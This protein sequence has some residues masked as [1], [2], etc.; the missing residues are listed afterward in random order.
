MF[1]ELHRYPDGIFP[2]PSILEKIAQVDP[3]GP[4]II[5][6]RAEQIA[7]RR[8]KALDEQKRLSLSYKKPAPPSPGFFEKI[9]GIF[10]RI[11]RS[12]YPPAKTSPL[13]AVKPEPRVRD[14]VLQT[15]NDMRM[16]ITDYLVQRLDV[17][18][19]LSLSHQEMGALF[20]V[21][22]DPAVGQQGHHP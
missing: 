3:E 17:C 22:V 8:Y 18:M 4:L 10:N 11:A 20:L 6:E 1:E 13:P 9:G 14:D 2:P 7:A 19:R 15:G 16:A 21:P 12:V 5:I